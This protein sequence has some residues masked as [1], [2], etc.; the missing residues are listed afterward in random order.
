MDTAMRR[1][2][3][4]VAVR[5]FGYALAAAINLAIIYAVQ[6]WPGWR[7][8]P[9]LTEETTRVLGLFTVSLLVS[10][11]ANVIYILADPPAIRAVG[12]VITTVLGIAVMVQMWRV[13]PF[14]FAAYDAP[15]PIVTRL[16]L[17]MAIA[18]SGV[19][20]L[21]QLTRLFRTTS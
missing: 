8:V 2:G 20:V 18:G 16:L 7:T 21:I 6:V 9:I 3:Q 19:A 5:R 4:L 1:S 13:F 17:A 10:A 15:W 12:E 11:V 14:D